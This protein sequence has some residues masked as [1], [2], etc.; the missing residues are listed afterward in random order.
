MATK[1]VELPE[2]GT[3]KLYKRKGARSI[4]L[5]VTRTGG[6]RV[7]LPQWLPFEAGVNFALSKRAW[8]LAQTPASQSTLLIK[9]GQ[10]VGKSHHMEFL[11]AASSR[12][13]SRID[14]TTIRILY[15]HPFSPSD[16]AVQQAAEKACIRAL[17]AQASALLPQRLQTLADKHNLPFTSV[18]VK[19][20]TGRWGSCDA[21]KHITLSIFLMQL[22]WH[23]IDYVLL[24][25]LTHTLVLHHGAD[26]WRE[27]ERHLAS[28]KRLRREIRD[29]QPAVIG[30]DI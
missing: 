15:P 17:R 10:A 3:L 23:L 12:V 16:P 6:V 13:S 9:H 22:P 14:G 5:S 18:K 1:H 19:R 20:L 27:F 24:H 30:G 28:V 11:A 21:D 7:S 8:I 2:I 25:E 26:F 4:R 29:Y